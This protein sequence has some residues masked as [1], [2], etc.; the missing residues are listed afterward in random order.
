MLQ[1]DLSHYRL[2]H[3]VVLLYPHYRKMLHELRHS[4]PELK[5]FLRERRRDVQKVQFFT[6]DEE[7]RQDALR[8]LEKRYEN[9]CVSSSV[10]QN[11]EINHA[12]ANKGEALKALAEHLG[13]P[14]SATMSFGDGL[15]DLS[16][17]REAG[18]GVAMANACSEA[19]ECADVLT[20]SCDEDGVALAIEKYC[21]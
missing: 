3:L 1:L 7:L 14:I 12:R 9:L 21:F 10:D 5:A 11:V 19:K 15:N 13:V 2:S 18:L 20:A 17:L 8:N 16:M 6:R 4:V